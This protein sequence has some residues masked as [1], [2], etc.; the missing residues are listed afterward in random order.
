MH[1]TQSQIKCVRDHK[2]ITYYD[3]LHVL[4]NMLLLPCEGPSLF[5]FSEATHDQLV[6]EVKD[7]LLWIDE[8]RGQWS[9]GYMTHCEGK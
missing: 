5:L 4:N 2:G 9:Q 8:I 6:R 7:V 1:E 3:V